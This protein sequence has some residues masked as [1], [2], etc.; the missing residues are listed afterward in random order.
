VTAAPD[1]PTS[2]TEALSDQLVRADLVVD[3]LVGV[4]ARAPMTWSRR[5]W[6]KLGTV[7]FHEGRDGSRGSPQGFRGDRRGLDTDLH[8]FPA[9]PVSAYVSFE[10]FVVPALRKMMG[11][12]AG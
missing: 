12:D 7:S 2:F 1:D 5:R 11:A 10:L 8:A 4:Q 6:A 9:N 3:Q